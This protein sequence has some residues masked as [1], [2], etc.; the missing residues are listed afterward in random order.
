MTEMKV[1]DTAP[2]FSL[3]DKMVFAGMLTRETG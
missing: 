3:M 1:G 2:D